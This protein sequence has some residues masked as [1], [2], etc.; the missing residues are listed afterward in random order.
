MNEFKVGLLAIA[1]MGSVII[2]SLK[3]TSNQSG[4]GDYIGYKTI[5]RDASGIFPKTSIRVAGISAGRIKNIELIGNNALITFEVLKKVRV[6]SNSVLRIKSVGFLGD[7]FLEIHVG[8]SDKRLEEGGSILA[9][10]GAGLEKLMKNA[11]EIMKDVKDMVASMKETLAPSDDIPPIKKIL[12]NVNQITLDAKNVMRSLRDAIAGNDK[13]L[14]RTLENFERLSGQLAN[15]TDGESDDSIVSELKLILKNARK[16]SQD[17]HELVADIKN[18]KGTIGR[19][20]VEDE[21]IDDVQETLAGVKKLVTKMDNIRTEL[22]LYTGA[23]SESGSISSMHLRILPSPERFY[24]LGVTSSE[25]GPESEVIS[26]TTINGGVATIQSRKEKTRNQWRFDFQLGRTIHDWSFRGGIIESGG[27]LG[28]DYNLQSWNQRF[29]FEAYD[30]RE[31]LGMNFRLST[32][33]QI[34]NVFYG[35]LSAESR[36][37]ELKAITYILSGGLKFNDEDMKALLGFF[38]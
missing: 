15:E 3:I 18:G 26:S 6:T 12:E 28:L 7:K 34:K 9:E 8:D 4:F 19:L 20:L 29:S 22:T 1:A 16:M 36:S 2:M 32:Q 10:E 11:S 37:K 38:F 13:K 30:Y 17:M 35:K 14:N 25:F 21:I 24:Q 27:G 33:L 31:N 5:I 23:S